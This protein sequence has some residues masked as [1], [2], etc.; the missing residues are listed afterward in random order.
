MHELSITRRIVEIA[1]EHAGG[2]RV[3]RVTLEIGRLSLVAPDA[4]RFCFDVCARGTLL[5]G[6]ELTIIEI[7]GRGRCRRCGD[8]TALE[9][10]LGRCACGSPDIEPIAGEDLRIKQMEIA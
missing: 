5:E 7:P 2:G 6:A 3:R 10:L 1:S 9:D 4:I 8:E